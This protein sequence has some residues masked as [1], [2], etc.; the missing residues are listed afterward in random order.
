MGEPTQQPNNDELD[1]LRRTNSEL[2]AKNSTRKAKIVE[3]EASVASLQAAVAEREAS[4]RA[5]T[6]DGP[7]RQMCESISTA[8]E[9]FQ[10]QLGKFFK[11]E[12]ID[13]KLTF[14]T[15]DGEPV[16]D[17]DGNTV[18]FERDALS[19]FLIEGNDVRARTFRAICV[20]S[21]ASGGAGLTASSTI[22]APSKPKV[23]F[24]LR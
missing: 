21:K 18:P 1:T 7:V 2:V 6:I 10:E 11:V 17:K 20:S 14:L 8:P 9:L 24:G 13:G 5:I 22:A 3:L 19:K 15:T 16:K 12:L 4:I 23:Q